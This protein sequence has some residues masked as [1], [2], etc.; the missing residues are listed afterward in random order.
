MGKIL[1]AALFFLMLG[2]SIAWAEPI[3]T[4]DKVIIL[5]DMPEIK[6]AA[7]REILKKSGWNETDKRGNPE[8]LCLIQEDFPDAKLL[9]I[10][11]STPDIGHRIVI[12]DDGVAP[13]A[14][15]KTLEKS[16]RENRIAAK[17]LKIN[18]SDH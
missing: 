15:L 16:C 6:S 8:V 2:G 7:V 5:V 3:F 18:H 12:Q 17:T 14:L 9:S 10:K 11:C 1:T 4:K 13:N